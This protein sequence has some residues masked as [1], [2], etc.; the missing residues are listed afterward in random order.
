MDSSQVSYVASATSSMRINSPPSRIGAK[1]QLWWTSLPIDPY[2][3]KLAGIIVIMR[4]KSSWHAV[5][6]PIR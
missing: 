3:S 4:A 6:C 5:V 1:F 2:H